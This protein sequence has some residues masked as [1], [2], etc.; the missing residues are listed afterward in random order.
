MDN[1]FKYIKENMGIDTEVSYPYEARN[2][3]C[4]FN[5]QNVGATDTVRIF[6]FL[7]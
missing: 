7:S 4:R 2:D 5:A 6:L 3:Q 1:A